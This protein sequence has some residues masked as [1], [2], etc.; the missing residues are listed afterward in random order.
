MGTRTPTVT[1]LIRWHQPFR[2]MISESSLMRDG[3]EPNQSR[4]LQESEQECAKS[5]SV[6]VVEKV[7]ES[8]QVRPMQ[9]IQRS[10]VG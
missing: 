6:K 3:L 7:K 1:M 4:A 8:E 10:P 5:R 2:L 9:E